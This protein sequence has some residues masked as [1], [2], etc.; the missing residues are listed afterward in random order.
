MKSARRQAFIAR[1]TKKPKKNFSFLKILIPLAVIVFLFL[2]LKINTR[3]WNGADKI[4]YTFVEKNGDVGVTVIDPTLSEITTLIIPG[5]TQVDVSRNY[6][7]FRIKNVWQMGI[8]EKVGGSLLS[9]T[10]TENFLF[11]VFLWSG[12]ETGIESGKIGA[13]IHFIFTPSSTNIPFGDRIQMALFSLKMQDLGKT[14]IN[15]GKSQFLDKKILEDGQIGYEITGPISGR[16]TVFFSDDKLGDQNIKVNIT[17]FTN[18]P[19]ISEKLGQIL[20]VIGGKVVSVDKKTTPE[21]SDCLVSGQNQR[22]VKEVSNLFNCKII[23]NQTSF[24]LDIK[25]GQRFAKRF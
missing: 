17:D 20:Q 15:L 19:G 18:T 10:V 25:I 6:G 5:D 23:N 14:V 4:S 7:I 21:D 22:V 11:P 8:N 1:K 9:E 12:N 13:L 24:D 3:F 2:F 16:L